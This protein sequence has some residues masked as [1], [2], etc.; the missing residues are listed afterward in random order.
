MT[1][2]DTPPE[3]ATPKKLVPRER[4]ADPEIRVEFFLDDG[5]IGRDLNQD[6]K[7]DPNDLDRELISQPSLYAYY[8][9]LNQRAR[10][11]AEKAAFEYE[12]AIAEYSKMARE[13][14]SET[15]RRVTDKQIE[16]L[17]KSNPRILALKKNMIDKEGQARLLWCM[18]RALDQKKDSLMQLCNNRRKE[19]EHLGLR[20]QGKMKDYEPPVGGISSYR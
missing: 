5:S 6:L 16:S 20:V 9:S 17:V 10:Y 1:E 19:M 18:E 3:E 11:V 8:A 15:N 13:E 14:L 12:K 4:Q 7:I 2:D